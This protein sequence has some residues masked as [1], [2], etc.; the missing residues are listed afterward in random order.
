M[1]RDTSRV[2]EPV[3]LLTGKYR[4]REDGRQPGGDPG[5]A[6][7]GEEAHLVDHPGR[8]DAEDAEA[9]LDDRL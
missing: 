8:Q 3:G 5:A 6:V 4:V 7:P 2:I 9:A 1:A